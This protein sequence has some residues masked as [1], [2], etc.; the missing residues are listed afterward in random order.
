MAP[1]AFTATAA[2]TAE[3]MTKQTLDYFGWLQNTMSTFRLEGSLFLF[4]QEG[5]VGTWIFRH[6][7]QG[8]VGVRDF[9]RCQER[10][11]PRRVAHGAPWMWPAAARRPRPG[12]H[13]RLCRGGR[14]QPQID[15]HLRIAHQCQHKSRGDRLGSEAAVQKTAFFSKVLL[16]G[17]PRCRPP[18]RSPGLDP[19][20]IL[21]LC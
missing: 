9:L 13:K 18:R 4:R 3:Q 16:L 14:V 8:P 6:H 10:R 7:Q 5:P 15:W 2:Q 11:R 21:L 1:E 17:V 19:R 20:G 12:V